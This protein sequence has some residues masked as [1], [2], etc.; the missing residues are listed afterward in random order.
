M[1]KLKTKSL[2][3]DVNYIL[4]RGNELSVSVESGSRFPRLRPHLRV[5]PRFL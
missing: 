5:W 1:M 4:P 3:L 2:T